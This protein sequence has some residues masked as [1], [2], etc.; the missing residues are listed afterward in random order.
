MAKERTERYKSIKMHWHWGHFVIFRLHHPTGSL[1]FRDLLEYTYWFGF[2][3][4]FVCLIVVVVA[5]FI[6][7]FFFCS[8]CLFFFCFV[9]F[10]LFFLLEKGGGGGG[11]RDVELRCI[12]ILHSLV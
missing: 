8:F 3:R 6:A 12:Y 10:L 9:Y 2:A 4:C 11:G 5:V 7:V 1:A